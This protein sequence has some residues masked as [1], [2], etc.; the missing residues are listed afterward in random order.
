MPDLA[1]GGI[2][3][4]DF[5]QAAL[6]GLTLSVITY[7]AGANLAWA[8]LRRQGPD[9]LRPGWLIQAGRLIYYVLF[10]YAL[11]LRGAGLLAAALGLLGPAPLGRSILGWSTG[12]LEGGLWATGFAVGTWLVLA[13]SGRI[14]RPAAGEVTPA[15]V[16][17]GWALVRDV[18]FQQSHWAFYRAVFTVWIGAYAALF[19]SLLVVVLEAAADPRTWRDLRDPVRAS[20]LIVTAAM[21]WASTGVFLLTGNFWLTAI[22]HLVALALLTPAL[23]PSR[24]PRQPAAG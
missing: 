23:A 24:G 21:A 10:P 16:P 22:M 3:G 20:G 11:L 13:W 12:W 15:S 7:V 1:A 17:T 9:A 18:V 8:L 5:R 19:A 4:L 14:V 2:A 6:F